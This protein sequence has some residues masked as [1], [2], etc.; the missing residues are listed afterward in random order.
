M[1]DAVDFVGH[2]IEGLAG[3]RYVL[4]PSFRRRTH[5]R[6]QSQSKRETGVEMLTFGG[7]FFF[8]SIIVG[9]LIW[10]ILVP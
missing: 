8:V 9:A 6:W 3:W 5:M 2:C 4:S 10:S 7:S 1:L